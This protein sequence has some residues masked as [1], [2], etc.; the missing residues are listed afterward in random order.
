MDVNKERKVCRDYLVARKKFLK[1]ANKSEL[2]R[3][4]DNI[5]GSRIGE[6]IAW[7]F[8]DKQKRKPKM[9][10]RAN[11]EGHDM[12]CKDGKKISVKLISPENKTG[13]T[14]RLGKNWDEF[15]LIIL[16]DNYKVAKIG[17][18]TRSQFNKD[19]K[20]RSANPYTTRS[21]L[22]E[23]GLF[24]RSRGRVYKKEEVSWLI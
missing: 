23:K 5:I 15:L 22:G 2:L 12:V 16:G 24:V 13:R 7:E 21:M 20:I 3:G 10:E 14:T 6:F 1:F 4:N 9:N 18:I 8:L 19:K 11:V 17:H